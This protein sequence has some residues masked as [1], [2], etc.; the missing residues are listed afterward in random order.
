MSVADSRNAQNEVNWRHLAGKPCLYKLTILSD[1]FKVTIEFKGD[2]GGSA[3][4][5]TRH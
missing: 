3:S 4:R 1:G 2:E 5:R